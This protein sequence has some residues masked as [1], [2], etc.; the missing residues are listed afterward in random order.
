MPA[1]DGTQAIHL[2]TWWQ[3]EFWTKTRPMTGRTQ[4]FL[5]LLGFGAAAWLL[6]ARFVWMSGNLAQRQDALPVGGVAFAAYLLTIG[7][8]TYYRAYWAK[9]RRATKPRFGALSRWLLTIGVVSAFG[10]TVGLGFPGLLTTYAGQLFVQT[11]TFGMVGVGLVFTVATRTTE[12]ASG[13]TSAD[14]ASADV[15]PPGAASEAPASSRKSQIPP[16][17]VASALRVLAWQVYAVVGAAVLF[18][19][20]YGVMKGFEAYVDIPACE[21]VCTEHGYRFESLVTGKSVYNCNCQGADGRH[22]F[23]DRANVGGGTGVLGS[24][25]DWLV[26]TV[27]ILGAVGASLT[28]VIFVIA[29]AGRTP[30]SGL[31]KVYK[32]C[33]RFLV[34]PTNEARSNNGDVHSNPGASKAREPARGKRRKR[35]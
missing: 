4:R 30:N 8:A 20:A 25:F 27:C 11:M 6:L 10:L 21:T 3:V 35:S 9:P 29:L 32:A 24:V 28:L 34:P 23:H 2:H 13:E 14:R 19:P 1:R 16:S 12:G 5:V 33:A 31:A 17:F 7:Y 18:A 22:T 26:R 15:R